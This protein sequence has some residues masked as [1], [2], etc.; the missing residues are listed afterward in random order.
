MDV[1]S[2]FLPYLPKIGQIEKRMEII[3]L[4]DK[5]SLI[6]MAMCVFFTIWPILEARVGIQK[7]F[8]FKW[9]HPKVVLVIIR[10]LVW[11]Q[12]SIALCMLLCPN[13]PSGWSQNFRLGYSHSSKII[14]VTKLSF[15][16]IIPLGVH[17]FGK[18]TVW[19]LIYFLIY[20]Y[21]SPEGQTNVW[22]RQISCSANCCFEFANG[23]TRRW[24]VNALV[25]RHAS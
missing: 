17:H 9:R 8:W 3:I 12:E 2:V 18:R 11:G 20:A 10:P 5:Y 4:E 13:G 21:W 19:S 15:C 16:Q 6:S 14:R 23:I 22:H 24:L 1:F 25:T 7:Y